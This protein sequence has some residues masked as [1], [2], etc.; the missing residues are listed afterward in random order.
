MFDSR[1]FSQPSEGLTSLLSRSFEDSVAQGSFVFFCSQMGTG[2]QTVT[3]GHTREQGSGGTGQHE[4]SLEKSYI[5][6]NLR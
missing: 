4:E 6:T 5:L 3:Q 2:A 1:V